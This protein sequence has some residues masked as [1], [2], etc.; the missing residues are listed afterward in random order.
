MSDLFDENRWIIHVQDGTCGKLICE[1][2]A[3]FFA[4][5]FGPLHFEA[6]SKRCST[7]QFAHSSCGC[8]P[9]EVPPLHVTNI[10]RHSIPLVAG[11]MHILSEVLGL[12]KSL[13]PTKYFLD[14]VRCVL[15]D[16]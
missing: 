16:I 4:R 11:V 14:Y 15:V 1:M 10:P 3:N 7:G 8:W 9:I 6:L 2:K 5:T 12:P 13:L